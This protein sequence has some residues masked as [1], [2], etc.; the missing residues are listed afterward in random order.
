MYK[1]I[2]DISTKDLFIA[3]IKD[4][5]CIDYIIKEDL[6]KKTD[7]L[8]ILFSNIIKRNKITVNNINHFYCTNGPGSFTG[9]RSGYIFLKTI[10]MINNKNLYTC[11]SLTFLA[12]AFYK[13]K[14]VVDARSQMQYIADFN[15]KSMIGKINLKESNLPITIFD[16][17]DFLA[18]PNMYIDRFSKQNDLLKTDIKYIKKPSI[19]KVKI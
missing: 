7:A 19:G 13:G 2:V 5:E 6:I 11:D 9:S 3:L 17:K 4:D 8:P 15:N 16:L 10:C 18:H 14:V 1:I 12:K